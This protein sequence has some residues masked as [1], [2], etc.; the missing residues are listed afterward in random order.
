[1][2]I[3]EPGTGRLGQAG[4]NFSGIRRYKGPNCLFVI[5]GIIAILL[6][7]YWLYLVLR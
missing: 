1:M 6:S 3:E 5:L 4:P 2:P 7:L